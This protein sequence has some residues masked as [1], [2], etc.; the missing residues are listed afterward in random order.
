MFI[1]A[2]LF[3]TALCGLVQAELKA[4][5]LVFSEVL[6][7]PTGGDRQDFIE[8][9]NPTGA[10]I[11]TAEYR[12]CTAA[13]EC[14]NLAG[15]LGQDSYFV[16]CS[17]LSAYAFCRQ[18]TKINLSSITQ[19]LLYKSGDD[20][21]DVVTTPSSP[22][23]GSSYAR[24]I[25]ADGTQT[26][27]LAFSYTTTPTV[28]VGFLGGTTVTPAPSPMPP[29]P[30][31]GIEALLLN[32]VST[33][34][35]PNKFVE[36]AYSTTITLSAYEV[37]FY[38]AN[39]SVIFA[40]K[41][42][43]FTVGTASNGMT[44]AY[45]THSIANDVYG[46][47][48]TGAGFIFDFV[49]VGGASITAQAGAASGS[50][51]L[52]LGSGR[53]FQQ[54]GSGC[55]SKAFNWVST[56]SASRGNVNPNQNPT[57]DV[58]VFL[59]EISIGSNVGNYVEFAFTDG[60]SETELGAYVIELYSRATNQLFASFDLSEAVLGS[61]SNGIRFAYVSL[62]TSRRGLRR[63]ASLNPDGIALANI[64]TNTLLEF[65]SIGSTSFTPSNGAAQGTASNIW[66]VDF[67]GGRV[68][69]G[70]T[71]TGCGKGEFAFGSNGQTTGAKNNLQTISCSSS[72]PNTDALSPAPTTPAPTP[73]PTPFPT[74][75]PTINT[76]ECL[77]VANKCNSNAQCINQAIGFTCECNAGYEGNGFSCTDVD[78]CVS[79]MPCAAIG[80]FC[81]DNDGTFSC[82][83]LAGFT[84]NGITC[85]DNDECANNPCGTNAACSNTPGDFT[86]TCE[87][88]YT[89][90]PKAS[91]PCTDIDECASDPCSSNGF[92][93]NTVGSFVC[94][95][96]AG[97]TGDGFT[98]NDS[99]ECS[100][101]PCNSNAAC[102]NTAGG[103]SCDCN[104]GFTGNGFSCASISP[105]PTPNPTPGPTP[106]S[107]LASDS[108]S[109]MPTVTNQPSF[110]I[111]PSLTSNPSAVPSLSDE[112]SSTNPPSFSP[113]LSVQPSITDM[114]S[115]APS[116]SDA[117]TSN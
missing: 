81:V 75:S 12:V 99:N 69:G 8:L 3:L 18:V 43:D 88:G 6:F 106:T 48:L 76:N 101:N 26:S 13:D 50:T 104:V 71:G 109:A 78:E 25:N 33:L 100:S 35:G 87:T 52:S 11:N 41:L 21:L 39:G 82:G 36:I 94:A 7:K 97:F 66:T 24:G 9:Y 42:Q 62:D 57:C 117:P 45:L 30:I 85:T 38:D 51:S 55:T 72:D 31:A 28:G 92:C 4:D 47:A 58:V 68:F 102:T 63:L 105:G 46:V 19:L 114:P 59:N 5:R 1:R 44:F 53:V 37:T 54:R 86:C 74:P 83:C 108:P 96:N 79:E 23:I 98:C 110:S 64:V 93:T 27:L 77:T 20:V 15:M 111:Q 112:P 107:D 73:F 56:N 91:I 10:T 17:D 29:P 14:T 90:N 70:Y 80:G 2:L 67:S 16:L 49:S 65:S 115:A 34:S 84:G 103:F 89:G 95:C 113:S 61:E 22:P 116:L 60:L 40:S 32:E